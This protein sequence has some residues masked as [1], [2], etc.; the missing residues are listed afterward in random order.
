MLLFAFANR[1]YIEQKYNEKNRRQIGEKMQSVLLEVKNKLD[2]EETITYSMSDYVNR[3]LSHFSYVFFTD[4]H[5]YSP[6]GTLVA[7]SQMRMFN[8]GLVSR[9]MN[10]EAFVHLSYLDQTDYVHEERIG[11]L[12]YISAYTPFYS[13]SGEL[14][15]YLNLPYFAKQVELENEVY[16]FLVAVINIFVLLFILSIVV[17]LF[18]SQWI[19][20]PLR[21]IRESLA[22]IELGKTNKLIPYSSNDE[23]GLLVAEYNAKVSELE[24]NA[25]KLSQSE[26]ESAWREM[27][28]QVAH[29][30]KNPL[31][32]MKLSVQHLSRSITQ[33]HKV[34]EAQVMRLSDN[35]V[36][37]IDALTEIANAFSN[38]AR[39]PVA[40]NESVDLI[41]TI[42]NAAGLFDK[43][44]RASIYVHT[45]GIGEALVK[46][47]KEQ[48]I[49][50]FNNLIKNALQSI[51]EEH[52][53]EIK[54]RISK[55][56]EVY[57][58]AVEDNG[59]GIPESDYGKI[60]VPN[61]TTKSR[62]MGLGLAITK[63]I[64]ESSGG[65][66]WFESTPGLGSTFFV[67]IPAA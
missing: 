32:P 52:P 4:I 55:D 20:A 26:R 25:E 66:I 34:D 45:N 38:F 65:K 41:S 35:L 29:E 51:P 46:S 40:K 62:G 3:L 67:S 64:V 61:F 54:I 19:T 39:M 28:K 8:E 1:Y 27:A 9:R 42:Q 63:S 47:D 33:G 50:V 49:R 48:I 37:Q 44:E 53:G 57:T 18:I 12:T 59:V 5:L 30:I 23:I 14:L 11:D 13:Q 24:H 22:E 36:E 15:A 60:F 2:E 31:T 56:A 21:A 43:F 16:S 58:V 7:S 10:P 17:G 6:E